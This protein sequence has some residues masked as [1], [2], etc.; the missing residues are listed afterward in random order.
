MARSGGGVTTYEADLEQTTALA[1]EEKIEADQVAAALRHGASSPS[2]RSSASTRSARSRRTGRRGSSGSSCSRCSSCCPYALLM[3]EAGSTFTEEGGPYEWMKLAWGRFVGGIGAVL[4]WVTNPLW[5]GG[6]LA[7]ISTEA[8]RHERVRA[9]GTGRGATTSSSCSSSGSRS[10]SRS[11]RCATASGSRTSARSCASSRSASSRSRSSSTAPSTA[12]TASPAHD[13]SPTRAVF[14]A[15]VPVLLFNYVGFELQNGAAEEMEN[16]SRDV[17]I[18]VFQAG[19][20]GVLSYVIP[21]LGILLVLP[22]DKVTGIG[23]FIDAVTE[24]FTRLRRRRAHAADPDDARLH[25][26]PGH[27][28]RRLD[29]R[30]R[31]RPGRRRLRRRVLGLVRRL[32][33]AASARRFAST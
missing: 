23:G 14:I 24:V 15:L 4:Y 19:V 21:I 18:S 9:S 22:L 31:P 5:V 28:G 13:A 25:R 32:Q 12:S 30:L 1:L 17:P 26:Q 27:V 11:P 33:P 6:S 10:A 3:A 29:D 7:F 20:L 8:W 2:A 16:P